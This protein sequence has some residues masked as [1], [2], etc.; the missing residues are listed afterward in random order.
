MLQP[1][2]AIK[3]SKNQVRYDTLSAIRHFPREKSNWSEEHFVIKLAI[4]KREQF[5]EDHSGEAYCSYNH[6]S[7]L[8]Q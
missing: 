5:F 8:S 6:E 2:E 1:K 3:A 4:C 7:Q